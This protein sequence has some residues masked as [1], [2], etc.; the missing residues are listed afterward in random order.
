MP[1]QRQQLPDTASTAEGTKILEIRNMEGELIYRSIW[2]AELHC[3]D[4]RSDQSDRRQFALSGHLVVGRRHER[5]CDLER[6][7]ACAGAWFTQCTA[8]V[9][10]MGESV[11]DELAS[12]SFWS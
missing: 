6:K 10:L 9:V 11:E 5:Q 1:G 2:V 8:N 12:R 3:P 7:I 4:R